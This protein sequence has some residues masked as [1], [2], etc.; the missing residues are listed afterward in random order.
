M[1]GDKKKLELIRKI[2]KDNDISPYQI[3][4]NTTLSNKTAYNILNN[5]NITPRTKTINIILE[6]LENAIVGT[7]GNL[8][9]KQEYTTEF[10]N[11]QVAESPEN[12]QLKGVPYYDVEF[13]AGFDPFFNDQT[14][15]PAYYVTD[16]Y[17]KDCDFIVRAS[18]KSMEKYIKHGEAVGLKK[19]NDW[20]TF[21]TLGEIY[22]IVTKNDLRTIKTIAK[23]EKQEN[24]KLISKPYHENK[25]EYKTQDIPKDMIL[26]LFKVQASKFLF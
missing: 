4:E 10:R 23:S 13:A 25:E 11:K 3:G 17:F 26:C 2:A 12:Y 6:Y 8:K 18:G 19:V 24:Y 15:K 1:L 5:D 14:L 20:Q 16:P 22:G 7:K 9:L 21:F